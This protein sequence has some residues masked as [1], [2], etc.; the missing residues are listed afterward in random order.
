MGIRFNL[1]DVGDNLLG[2]SLKNSGLITLKYLS[3]QYA[4]P[5]DGLKTNWYFTII[6]RN[7]PESGSKSA[8]L[9]TK[10]ILWSGPMS[11]TS[12]GITCH[13]RY[14]SPDHR[15]VKTIYDDVVSP[16]PFIS[17]NERIQW[18]CS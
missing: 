8:D 11:I 2:Q 4:G 13:F 14:D 17:R 16:N 9:W 7:P 15:E 10:S 3:H 5:P 1:N 12:T 18:K 6:K